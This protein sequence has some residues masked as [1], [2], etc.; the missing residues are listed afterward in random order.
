MHKWR[1]STLSI[2]QQHYID[3]LKTI[4]FLQRTKLKL[5]CCRCVKKWPKCNHLINYKVSRSNSFLKAVA[6]RKKENPDSHV[7]AL[8]T[9]SYLVISCKAYSMTQFHKKIFFVFCCRNQALVL[10]DNDRS[11]SLVVDFAVSNTK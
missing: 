10:C 8:K 2:N 6:N 4:F 11:H 5:H 9:K 3:A 7:F 1:K